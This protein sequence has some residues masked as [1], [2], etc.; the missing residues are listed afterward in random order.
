MMDLMEMRIVWSNPATQ[1]NSK[2]TQM[3]REA[4]KLIINTLQT[5]TRNKNNWQSRR[6]RSKANKTTEALLKVNNKI[7][8]KRKTK[9]Q[10]TTMPILFPTKASEY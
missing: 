1:N 5:E 4:S 2:K 6:K 7:I 10:L 9:Y 8:T 3:K